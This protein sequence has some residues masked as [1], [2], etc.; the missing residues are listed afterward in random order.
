MRGQL[1]ARLPLGG[2]WRYGDRVVLEG[3]PSAVDEE[4]S[5]SYASYL[6]RQGITAVLSYPRI[7]LLKHKRAARCWR[8]CMTCAHWHWPLCANCGRSPKFALMAG[9]LLG[10][11]RDLP[12]R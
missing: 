9:I 11:D 7:S 5:A 1:L 8:C 6:A 10:Y 4:S 3:S 12:P 2:D